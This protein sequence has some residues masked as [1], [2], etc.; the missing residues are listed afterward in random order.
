MH[1]NSVSS[2][3]IMVV[4]AGGTELFRTNLPNLDGGYQVNNEYNLDISVSL[5]SG[6]RVLEITNA[7]ID[8][9]YLD[10]VRVENLLP[11][12]YSGNWLP[13]PE[14]IGLRGPHESLLYIVAPGASFPASA[15]NATLPV[16][17]GK[18]A[19]LTNWPAGL[20]FA[21]WYDPATG[22]SLGS[23][24]ANSQEN[25]LA[26][27]LPDFLA[28]LAGIV[29]PPPTLTASLVSPPGEFKLQLDSETGG[30]YDIEKS[31]DLSMW[32]TVMSVTNSE[33]RLELLG[34]WVGTNSRAF[35]RAKH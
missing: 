14:A 25:S 16:Q 29:Y 5:P 26:L 13:S 35:F 12:T 2:G 1:L 34:T 30:N 6:Q 31:V 32:V 4:R 23:S 21:E 9:F 27:A 28:D 22:A 24:Q 3:A 15:T 20:F 8:W 7:G 17:A 10:W 33:G 11:T 19:V 18:V